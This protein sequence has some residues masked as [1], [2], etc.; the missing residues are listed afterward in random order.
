MLKIRIRLFAVFF[1]AI[2]TSCGSDQGTDSKN[3]VAVTGVVIN[4]PSTVILIAGTETLSATVLPADA[5]NKNVRWSTNESEIADVDPVTGVVTAK[6][7]GT[8]QITVTT[9]DG[10]KTAYC[11]VNVSAEV[12]SVTGVTLKNATSI[13]VGQTE[14]LLPVV[15]PADATNQNVTWTSS[16][17]TVADVDS[18]T[19]I[20]TAR[21][22]GITIIK[23]TTSD[24]AKTAECAV[25]VTPE[26]VSVTGV[27]LDKSVMTVVVG[28]S[29]ILTAAIQPTGATIQ[30]VTW[31]SNAA[32]IADVS[33]SGVVSAKAVGTATITV[34]TTDGAHTADCVIKVIDASFTT[35]SGNLVVLISSPIV[36][37]NSPTFPA[38]TDDSLSIYVPKPFVMAETETTYSLWKE[39]YD[40]ATTE[41]P[42]GSG[43]RADGGPVYVF[44]NPGQNGSDRSGKGL[45]IATST[46]YPVTKVNWRD[47]IVWC[48]ALTEYFNAMNGTS[49]EFV[50]C[51]TDS[52]TT[53]IRNSADVTYGSLVNVTAG[54]FDNPYVNESAKGFRLPSSMEWEFAARYRGKD[55]TNAILKNGVY[56]T[57]G[58]SASGAT[59][60]Y[61][62]N[63]A[64]FAVS[65]FSAYDNG[66]STGVT[67]TAAVK[68]KGAKGKNAFGLYDMSGNVY[69]WCFSW[70][71][72]NSDR[73][74]RGGGFCWNAPSVRI[75]LEEC[76]KPF[77]KDYFVGFRF[78]RTQ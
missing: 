7:V 16:N 54:S 58:N 12:V 45:S 13:S 22:E 21:K 37:G 72:V 49:L 78:V 40:W 71:S 69:E 62:S 63:A 60:A 53:P 9:E 19:G 5:T 77:N 26:V 39:V 11:D 57:K 43:T 3:D 76:R 14:K 34:T 38:D 61:T 2:I 66:N 55:S 20:V 24:G 28:G 35:Q 6:A 31:S 36:A 56:Y 75:G 52:Y 47:S 65:V 59:A 4:K 68:S 29:E 50:Y 15:Q 33:E 25:T 42:V 27:T 23:V 8:T 44:A 1:A 67:S 64:T 10:S 46:K 48:N 18:V 51:T 41:S 74:C 70:W 73:V 30:S 17:T 32:S